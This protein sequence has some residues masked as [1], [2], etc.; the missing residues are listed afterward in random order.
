MERWKKL[1]FTLLLGAE[2]GMPGE[3]LESNFLSLIKQK[4]RISLLKKQKQIGLLLLE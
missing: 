1:D 2:K 4:N 3:K